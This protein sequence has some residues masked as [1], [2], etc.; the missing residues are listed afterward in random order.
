MVSHSHRCVPCP[1]YIVIIFD[2]GS[3]EL[4][5]ARFGF[6]NV[7]RL[8]CVAMLEEPY[9][10]VFR[11]A[12]KSLK[13]HGFTVRIEDVKGKTIAGEMHTFPGRESTIRVRFL[14][15]DD[16]TLM[17]TE[18]VSNLSPSR[19]R[20]MKKRIVKLVEGLEA[21][22]GFFPASQEP[23]PSKRGHPRHSG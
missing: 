13:K 21:Q 19:D 15:E 2:N 4:K 12:M 3:E 20:R 11:G 9:P 1:T 10:Q 6:Q 23:Y 22:M 7:F 8:N 14:S 16:R 18:C 17:R 5:L